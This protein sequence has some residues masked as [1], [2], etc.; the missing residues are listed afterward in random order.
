[1][2]KRGLWAV[3]A[4]SAWVWGGELD[5]V[6]HLLR[7][8]SM[9]DRLRGVE[10]CIAIDT[11]ASLRALEGALKE[12]NKEAEEGA[13]RIDRLLARQIALLPQLRRVLRDLESGKNQAIQDAERL[14]KKVEKLDA[15]I[16]RVQKNTRLHLQ[17]VHRAGEGIARFRN[18]ETI[19]RIEENA[20]REANILT[21]L[22]YI[23]ALRHPSRKRSLPV[24]LGLLDER[25]PRLRACG[26]RSLV[27]FAREAGVIERVAQLVDDECWSVRLGAYQV[28][29]G[30]PFKQAVELLV[31]AAGREQGRIAYEVDGYLEHRTGLSFPQKPRHWVVWWKK[32]GPAIKAGTW[33]LAD[34]APSRKDTGETKTEAS[35]FRIPIQSRRVLFALDFSGSMSEPLDLKD[36]GMRML[37]KKYELASTRLGYA[38][39]E[40]IRAINSLP[41]GTLFNVLGY[42]DDTKRLGSR[43]MELN[44]RTR[45]R[46]VR[47]VLRLDTA[48][49][50]NIFSA[51][52]DAFADYLESGSGA[53]RFT[54]I[55][56]TVILLTDGIATRGRFVESEDLRLLA[57][58]WNKAVD[59]KFHCV[60]IGKGHDRA[61]LEALAGDTGG[62]YVDVTMGLRSLVPPK[63]IVPEGLPEAAEKPEPPDDFADEPTEPA[64]KTTKQKPTGKVQALMT[65]LEE[66]DEAERVM[67]ANSL[68]K[69]GTKAAPAA[70]L[71]AGLLT[72]FNRKVR[73]AASRAL[74]AIGASAVP[75]L[76][77]V[78]DGGDRDAVIGAAT[79]LAEI[80]PAA[81][82]ALKALE[83]QA[84]HE[85]EDARKA[86]RAAIAAVS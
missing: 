46:A 21:R 36:A 13:Y 32:H 12:S 81:K 86:V 58:T 41:D 48:D 77:E 67:A 20:V 2:G 49:L 52:Q 31:Q 66:G 37:M 34:A 71:L 83:K 23:Q 43:L 85:D 1:M 55:P 5:T 74:G 78:L 56:D 10:R 18:E 76:I 45:A 19:K 6:R 51:L 33:T 79:A 60:G 61:L 42:N 26:V 27:P 73:V 47:W 50:T 4:L 80:G 15:E 11:P 59:V 35:F 72:D 25:D 82:G 44:K 84:N 28:M 69:L 7:S 17:L 9:A 3:L 68:A 39:A 63:R 70:E 53:M 65:L 29:A 54:D 22:Y 24:I 16:A 14:I 75:H 30:A 57:R 8:D 64:A 62:Y 40:F 38:Q